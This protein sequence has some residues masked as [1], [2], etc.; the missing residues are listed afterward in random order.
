MGAVASTKAH[1]ADTAQLGKVHFKVECNAAAQKEFDLAMAYYHSFAWE[2]Y[3]ARL[4][5]IRGRA[6]AVVLPESSGVSRASRL[7]CVP[8]GA[9]GI[10]GDDDA[11]GART[12]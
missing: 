6:S 10:A 12:W 7:S 11:R 4:N 9:G 3:K 8:M 1:D 2:Q 5:R